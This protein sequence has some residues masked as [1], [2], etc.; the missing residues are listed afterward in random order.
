[1]ERLWHGVFYNSADIKSRH[2]FKVQELLLAGYQ[3]RY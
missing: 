3:G 1:M 2:P